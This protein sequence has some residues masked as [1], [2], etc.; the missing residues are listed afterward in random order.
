MERDQFERLALDHLDSVHRL[1]WQLT[2]SRDAAADLVQEVYLRAFRPETVARFHRP[3]VGGGSEGVRSESESVR[4]WLFTITHNT[5]YSLLKKDRRQRFVERSAEPHGAAPAG[6]GGASEPPEQAAGLPPAWDLHALDW[7]SV[8]DRLKRSIEGLAPEY[9][10]VLILWSVYEMK[11]REIAQTL[12]IPIGTVMSR[13]FRARK[14]LGDALGG[15]QGPA[16]DLGFG[17]RA[18]SR[19]GDEP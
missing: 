8:D 16:G 6:S 18:L 4:S 15:E 10:Q 1:A 3:A 5:F 12:E 17:A 13:L 7:D 11:Y 9:R 2:R 14:L 19:E